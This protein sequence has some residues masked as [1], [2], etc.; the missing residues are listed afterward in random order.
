GILT[1]VLGEMTSALRIELVLKGEVMVARDQR[2]V[3]DAK[4][5]KQQILIRGVVSRDPVA[6]AVDDAS[7]R[8][9]KKAGVGADVGEHDFGQRPRLWILRHP[10]LV[11]RPPRL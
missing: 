2:G 5:E 7:L 9:P 3:G 10:N 6:I 11:P 1:D 4:H 8:V